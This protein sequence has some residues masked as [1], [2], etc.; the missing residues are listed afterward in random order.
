MKF[1][2][3][4]FNKACIIAE[5]RN[6]RPFVSKEDTKCPFCLGNE[7]S[8]EKIIDEN[9]GE[10][11]LF[12]RIVPNRYPMTSEK[13][14]RGIHDVIIDT[15]DHTLH[16]KDFSTQHW[17]VLLHTIQKRWQSIMNMP[18]IRF[19]QV[20]KNYGEAAGA[21]I[22][23]SHWQLVALESLPYTMKVQYEAYN[24]LPNASCYLC[25]P[26]SQEEGRIIL[27]EVLWKVWIPPVPQ[28][29]YEAWLIP[30]QHHQHYGQ[31]SFIEI[32]EL[33]KLM[34][35]LL[36]AYHRLGFSDA[37]NICFMSG[38]VK[39]EYPYHFH[40]KLMLRTGRIAGFEIATGCHILSIAPQI[41][42]DQIEKI[43]KGMYK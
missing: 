5:T 33:G 4:T 32:K 22:T 14:A 3:K 41:Y 28:F 34:K 40:I 25:A 11:D 12:I 26:L 1:Y 31:L 35:D 15:H 37:F 19:I 8:L 42:A 18:F 29:P 38:D 36:Q 30:S 23:H 24:S 20:F 43:L 7:A 17:E 39:G 9:W 6:Q 13:G 16:P 10:D 2:Q 27:E 21:S